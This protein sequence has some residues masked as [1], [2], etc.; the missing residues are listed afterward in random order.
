[1]LQSCSFR[2]K[3]CCVFPSICHTVRLSI[4]VLLSTNLP[5]GFC[6]FGFFA[7]HLSQAVDNSDTHVPKN[8]GPSQSATWLGL[9]RNQL[10]PARHSCSAFVTFTQLLLWLCEMLAYFVCSYGP[11][12]HGLALILPVQCSSLVDHTKSLTSFTVVVH[13]CLCHGRIAQTLVVRLR[14]AW[15][16][17]NRIFNCYVA[18]CC[19]AFVTL[20]SRLYEMLHTLYAAGGLLSTARP[21]FYRPDAPGDG[22]GGHWL[23]RIEWHPA[24]WSL[25]L[26]LLIFPC[27]MKSR[28][29]LLALAHPGGQGKGPLKSCGVVVVCSIVFHLPHLEP[30]SRVA[31][32]IRSDGTLILLRVVIILWLVILCSFSCFILCQ[33]LYKF[34]LL[35]DCHPYVAVVEIWNNETTEKLPSTCL[36]IFYPAYFLLC[37]CTTLCAQVAEKEAQRR[38]NPLRVKK[39]FVLAALV[40]EQYHQHMRSSQQVKTKKRRPEVIQRIV[41]H[42]GGHVARLFGFQCIVTVGFACTLPLEQTCPRR[43]VSCQQLITC[44]QSV[45]ILQSYS[46]LGRFSKREPFG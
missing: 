12:K 33:F 42:I 43:T 25:C 22:G 30:R 3:R 45:F 24:G 40:I 1:M 8:V 26:P 17:L 28:T 9:V 4:P 31:I 18:S 38:S 34:L 23:V 5:S 10:S 46:R 19:S 13:Y 29:S 15:N 27:A 44:T 2:F 11:P 20:L 32:M 14:T 41:M 6:L 39:L 21:S 37:T 36:S 16:K 7:S 35:F